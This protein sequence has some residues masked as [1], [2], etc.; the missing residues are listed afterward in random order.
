ML[1]NKSLET[2]RNVLRTK[3]S[4]VV[5]GLH[6]KGWRQEKIHLKGWKQESQ[7]KTHLKGWKQESQ[8]KPN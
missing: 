8:V 4:G 2:R 6:L 5:Q 3:G 7:E 1:R